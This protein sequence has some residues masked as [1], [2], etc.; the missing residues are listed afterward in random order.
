VLFHGTET[1]LY[2][3]YS[4]LGDGT[5]PYAGLVFDKE[6][7]LYGTAESAGPDD[8]ATIFKVTP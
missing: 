1:V 3:F 7:N 6:G 4:N 8:G 5:H 2:S